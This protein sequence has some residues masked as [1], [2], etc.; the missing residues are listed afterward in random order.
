MSS[1][2][3]HVEGAGEAGSH[4]AARRGVDRPSR[5]DLRIDARP[6]QLSVVR[7]VAADLAMHQDFDLDAISDLRLAVDEACA[8]LIGLAAGDSGLHCRFEVRPQEIRM[9]A[10]VLSADSRAPRQDSFGWRVLAALVDQVWATTAPASADPGGHVVRIELV[11]RR[12]REV[13]G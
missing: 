3:P 11:K 8:E 1:A 10:E 5:V 7:A 13:D 4:A 2:H 9:A 12:T 6:G